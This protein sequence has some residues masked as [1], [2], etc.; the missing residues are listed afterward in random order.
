MGDH[1]KGEFESKDVEATLA[2]D[3]IAVKSGDDDSRLENLADQVPDLGPWSSGS[4]ANR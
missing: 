4:N 3:N 1:L 2:K